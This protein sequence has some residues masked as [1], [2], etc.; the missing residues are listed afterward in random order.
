LLSVSSFSLFIDL[1]STTK[2]ALWP[3]YCTQRFLYI[4]AE[5]SQGLQ[6]LSTGK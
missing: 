4:A 1:T 5:K 3:I 2:C 6:E